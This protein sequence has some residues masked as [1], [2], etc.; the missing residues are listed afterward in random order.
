MRETLPKQDDSTEKDLRMA[1]SPRSAGRPTNET[2]NQA[3]LLVD[4]AAI[5]EASTTFRAGEHG[6]NPAGRS[7]FGSA[8]QSDEVG[9]GRRQLVH[10]LR[11]RRKRPLNSQRPSLFKHSNKRHRPVKPTV[12]ISMRMRAA[13]DRLALTGVEGWGYLCPTLLTICGARPI[14][15]T[16]SLTTTHG[17]ALCRTHANGPCSSRR[18]IESDTWREWSTIVYAYRN[19]SPGAG[20]AN[21]KA[22]T[23]GQ[24]FMS[25]GHSARVEHFSRGGVMSPKF[26]A[27]PCGTYHLRVGGSGNG[28]DKQRK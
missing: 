27:V 24:G 17:D 16:M 9:R 3:R 26:I 8:N 14:R 25:R 4:R 15:L 1:A 10:L 28:D 13:P 11:L 12:R 2:V 22:G 18:Q 20:V 7:I 5:L 21:E 19:L 23:K 6:R